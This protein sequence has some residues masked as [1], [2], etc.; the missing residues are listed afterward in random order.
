MA[1]APDPRGAARLWLPASS[2]AA[3]TVRQGLVERGY[4]VTQTIA[5][6]PQVLE[7]PPHVLA[8][9]REGGYAA[10][11]LTS[12]MIAREIAARGPHPGTVLLSIGEP[13]TAALREAG[14]PV[15]GQAA[16]PTDAALAAA[17]AA[18]LAG[19]DPR[20]DVTAPP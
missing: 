11:V 9:L 3:D 16:Q 1:E 12:P 13:T 17:V 19:P 7:Q 6:R 20:G 2:A 4:T 14:L 18:A 10:V 8:A 5:Y 15:H